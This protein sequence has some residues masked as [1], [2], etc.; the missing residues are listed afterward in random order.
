MKSIGAQRVIHRDEIFDEDQK[1]IRKRQWIAAIDPIGGKTTQ[2]ILSSL[3]YGGYVATCGLVG[4]IDVQTT[5]IPFI[6]RSIQWIGVDS[7]KYPM[8]GRKKIWDRL[9][10]DLK[11][12]KLTNDIVNEITLNELP[13]TLKKI[14]EGQIRGRV[15][16]SFNESEDE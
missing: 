9:A 12:S 13:D 8:E 4:G 3:D 6:S 16:V 10:T 15:I 2:Y 5:V 7:V 14:L 1:S 11:P